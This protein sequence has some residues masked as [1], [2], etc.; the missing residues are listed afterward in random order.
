MNTELF[1]QYQAKPSIELRNKIVEDN[2]YM[3]DIL[4]RKYL[5]KGVDYDDLYQVGAMALVSAVE[6]FDISKGFEFRSFATPTI[7]GEIK[8]YFRDKQWSLKVPRRIKEIAMKVQDVKND[9]T[10]KLG[11]VPTINEIAEET[12]FTNEQ[13]IQA[14]ES[15]KAYGTYSLDGF[16]NQNQEES[17]ENPMDRYVGFEDAGY[18]KVELHEIFSNVLDKF[19]ETYKYIFKQRFIENKSQATIAKELGVSQMTISRAEKSI[20]AEFI[21][22]IRK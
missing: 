11:R 14:M 13:I 19:S 16:A 2:L 7:L 21:K 10:V 17:D 5:G 20:I 6:R 1:N 4:I 18:E 22:E 9:L 8:K 15:S 3:V 12:G